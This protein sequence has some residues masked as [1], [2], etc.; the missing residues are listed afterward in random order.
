MLGSQ[1]RFTAGSF[2]KAIGRNTSGA[3]H[4]W[5]KDSFTR[6]QGAIV[7]MTDGKKTFSGQLIHNYYVDEITKECI[8]E[9]NPK[10]AN[11]FSSDGWTGID[12]EQ[13]KALMGKPLALWL[14]SFYSTHA[15]PFDYKIETIWKLCGSE[16]KELKH[17]KEKLSEAILDLGSVTGWCME[18]KSDKLTVSKAPQDVIKR[19]IK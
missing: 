12:W 7:E 10:L 6:L 19:L 18:I 1:V 9:L 5:L 8:I 13:R 2:L 3:S 14:H 15:Q 16:A 11:L 17:F 4:E